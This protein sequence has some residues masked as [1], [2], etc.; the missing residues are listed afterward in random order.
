MSDTPEGRQQRI[1]ELMI[2]DNVVAV[3]DLATRLKV[4]PPTIRRDLKSLQR[5]GLLHRTHGGA[6]PIDQSYYASL[7]L[8]SSYEEQVRLHA[9]AKR[10]IGLAAASLVEDRDTIALTPG[11]TTAQV[12]RSIHHRHGV[13]LLVTS[14]NVAMELSNRQDLTVFVPGGFMRPSWFSLIGPATIRA[15]RDFYSDKVFIGV[16]GI[17]AEKGLTSANP[18][19][20]AVNRALIEQTNR[21]IVVADHTKLGGVFQAAICPTAEVDTIITDSDATD[22]AIAPFEALGIEVIRA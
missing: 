18:E 5:R 4:S 7:P 10:R 19:E 3:S 9:N 17:H 2:H 13:T 8:D 22:D 11:T 6:T 21:R 1:L 14:V 16:N 20:A 12:A 15:I